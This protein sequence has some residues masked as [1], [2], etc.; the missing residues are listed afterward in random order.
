ME[1]KYIRIENEPGCR[2]RFRLVTGFLGNPLGPRLSHSCE[3]IPECPTQGL[4]RS[5]AEKAFTD[6]EK[7]LDRQ[8]GKENRIMKNPLP[9]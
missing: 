3:A 4:T 7:Y 9:R 2:N 1:G 6:W 8:N 5:A